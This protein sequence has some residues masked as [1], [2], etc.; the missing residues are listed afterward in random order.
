MSQVAQLYRELV[1]PAPEGDGKAAP[2]LRRGA[3]ENAGLGE[4][5]Q[6]LIEKVAGIHTK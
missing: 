6:T 2:E 1:T 5:I 4:P 3:F